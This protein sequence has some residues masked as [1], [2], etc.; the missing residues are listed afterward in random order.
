MVES[1]PRIYT[2]NSVFG[3]AFDEEFRAPSQAFFKLVEGGLFILLVSD[4]SRREVELAPLRVRSLFDSL[5][6]HMELVS[7]DAKVLA[8]RDDYLAAGVVGSRRADDAAHVAAATIAGADLIV[9]WNFK[10]MVHFDK[11]RAYNKVN[12]SRGYRPIDIRSPL[13][14]IAYE[15]EGQDV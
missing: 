11:I 3:G 4:V 8:L 5:A 14:V 13:E 10:H 9:S 15:D 7:V 2:D 1:P 12:A 6:A